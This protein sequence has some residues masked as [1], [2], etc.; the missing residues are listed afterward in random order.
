MVHIQL[1]LGSVVLT[2]CALFWPSWWQLH[3]LLVVPSVVTFLLLL[4]LPESLSTCQSRSSL[5]QPPG[6][7]LMIILFGNQ[8]FHRVCQQ[9]NDTWGMKFIESEE[10]RSV[11][12]NVKFVCASHC[13]AALLCFALLCFAPGKVL[14]G[15]LA[16]SASKHLGSF[17]ALLGGYMTCAVGTLLFATKKSMAIAWGVACLGEEV[18]HILATTKLVQVFPCPLRGCAAS[19]Q[20]LSWHLRQVA[21]VSAPNVVAGLV[22]GSLGT[23]SA[24]GPTVSCRATKLSHAAKAPF[25]ASAASMALGDLTFSVLKSIVY[26]H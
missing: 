13:R 11:V 20:S 23:V 25:I 17:A 1:Q 9:T 7:R 18:A 10:T 14:G 5:F 3:G 15:L 21:L 2:I 26:S 24:F 16:A 12:L 8:F 19:W 4:S 6:R 22:A